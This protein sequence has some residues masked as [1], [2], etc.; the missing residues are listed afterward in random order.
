MSDSGLQAAQKKMAAAGVF[1]RAIEAFTRHYRELE[2]GVTGFI[3]ESEI[4][5]LNDVAHRDSLESGD[6]DALGRTVVVKLNGGLGTSMGLEQAKSLIEIKENISFL[7]LIAKQVLFQRSHFGVD[8]PV[9]LMNSFRTHDDTMAALAKF[10]DLD[11]G[12]GLSFFQSQEPKLLAKDLTPAVWPKDPSLEWC[13][14]GHG[15][16]FASLDD[17]GLL[18]QFLAAGYEFAFI[19][20]ADNLG[21]VVDPAIA[22][23]F[24]ESGA[25]MCLEV[26][27]RTEADAK[28]GHLVLRD[29]QVYLR[30]SAQ[31][32]PEDA[33]MAADISRHRFHNTNN[34]WIRLQSLRDKLDS[35][36]FHL[37]LIVN[38][39]TLDPLDPSSPEVIQIE[40]AM[41]AAINVFDTVNALHVTRDRFRPVKTTNDL[42]LVRSDVFA[43]QADF[44]LIQT[45][46]LPLID[47]DEQFYAILGDFEAR[48]SHAPS[49]KN[50]QSFTVVGDWSFEPGVSVS[51]H[52]ELLGNGTPQV[53]P[54][55]TALSG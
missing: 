18:N 32:A 22:Q 7:D 29:N 55:G 42:L 52:V 26:T 4:T 20:N 16:V 11:V 12:F 15:D 24:A 34:I 6:L 33:P 5:P 53:L 50:A 13:P 54:A 23:W 49:L 10:P 51:G 19:S 45:S 27:D 38:R 3:R 1:P 25:D 43:I 47:L 9:V 36:S 37:P 17:S 40:S 8:L 41:G 39:K 21:A 46:D 44:T 28:G 2:S 14:P 35:G 31:I 48:L 30:E